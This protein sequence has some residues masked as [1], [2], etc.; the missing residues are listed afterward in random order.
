MAPA[1]KRDV[2]VDD[3]IL[4]GIY[5]DSTPATRKICNH[6]GV[7]RCDCKK[8][9]CCLLLYILFI[10]LI[11]AVVGNVSILRTARTIIIG[12][13]KASHV[14]RKILECVS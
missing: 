7:H 4:C 6:D 10:S 11:G 14:I 12:R 8:N 13:L 9:I 1:A 2:L 3:P 5:V